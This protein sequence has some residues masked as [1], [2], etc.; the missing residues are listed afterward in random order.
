MDAADAVRRYKRLVFKMAKR[1][2]RP[3]LDIQDLQQEGFVGLIQADASYDPSYNMKFM[4]WACS[5]IRDRLQKFT[6]KNIAPVAIPIRLVKGSKTSEQSM[7]AVCTHA[8]NDEYLNDFCAA[9]EVNVVDR[10]WAKQVFARMDKL[11]K[12]DIEISKT[13]L[14]DYAVKGKTFPEI[15]EEYGVTKQRVHQ[16]FNQVRDYLQSAFR[17]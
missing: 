17:T 15:G 1:Y 14:I 10:I 16:E 9:P 7:A 11:H 4:S 13:I 3:G 2:W 12:R 8:E 5:V 6:R